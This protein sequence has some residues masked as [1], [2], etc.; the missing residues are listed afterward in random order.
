MR[1]TYNYEYPQKLRAGF[2]GA[3][4]HAFRNVY[5]TFAYA[6]ID[7]VAICD[8]ERERAES[9]A[10]IYGARQSYTN[11]HEML[12]TEKL[13]VVFIVT[14]YDAAGLPLYPALA[15]DCMKAGAHVWIEKPPAGRV[16]DVQAMMQVSRETGR[17]V[18]VGFKKMFFPAN[19]K[20][21][22]LSQRPEFGRIQCITARYPQALP[23]YEE[24]AN[25]LK[26]RGF[27]DHFVHPH[28]VL[29]FLGGP[30]ASLC[31]TRSPSGAASVAL[32]FKSGAIGNLILSHGQ[33]ANSFFERTEIIGEGENVIVDNNIRVTLYRKAQRKEDYGRSG[34]Y[35]DNWDDD[36][37]PL[38]WEPEFSLGQLH[39]KGL[40]LLGYA[41]EIIDYTT[42]L[43]A[44]QAPEYGTLDDALELL[45]IYEVYRKPDGIVHTL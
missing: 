7:L 17:Q 15:I 12:A 31:V 35:F 26:M 16:E 42:C 18:G 1:I 36:A 23:P 4:G 39:N 8:L 19:R 3:G 32:Q 30:L 13:D 11:H 14:G 21:H 10:R 24:R 43:L 37:S 41:P 45:R 44:G 20:A 40:F 34:D 25:N 27:L 33:S 29:R 9:C 28:S 2:I 38:H 5:P 6:P 22:A